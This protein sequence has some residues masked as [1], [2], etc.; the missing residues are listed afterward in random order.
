MKP[1]TDLA[2]LGKYF[3]GRQGFDKAPTYLLYLF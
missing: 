2:H 3:R 1:T